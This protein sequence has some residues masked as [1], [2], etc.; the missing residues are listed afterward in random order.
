MKPKENP[1]KIS[2]CSP[3]GNKEGLLTQSTMRILLTFSLCWSSLAAIA[4]ELK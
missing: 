1:M 4:T 3:D 2:T